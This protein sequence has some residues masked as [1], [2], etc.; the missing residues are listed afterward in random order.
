M[1]QNALLFDLDG[2]LLHSDPMHIK[3]FIDLFAEM[4]TDIDSEYYLSHIHGRHNFEIFS[5]HFPDRDPQE[6]AEIKEARFRDML[7]DSAPSMP[8]LITLLDQ[9]DAQGWAKAVVTNAPRQNA[10]VM[11]NAIGLR[12]R[13]PVLVIGEECIAGK[14]DPE[15]YLEAM[16]QLDV[17]PENSIAFEDSPSGLRA[18]KSAGTSVVG[19]RSSLPD[20]A[21]RAAGADIT[22][23][24]FNDSAL[25]E[26]LTRQ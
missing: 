11:L 18:A 20:A 10:E 15:P 26:F 16:R 13:F 12:D 1:T 4:G 7:G 6:M 5:E 24:D 2:T 9:A 22:I 23:Q 14:P 21:L 19:V 25:S 17:R 8:G 3:V